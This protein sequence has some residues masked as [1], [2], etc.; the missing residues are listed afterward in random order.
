MNIHPKRAVSAILSAV[1]LLGIASPPVQALGSSANIAEETDPRLCSHHEA[2]T[3]ACG[4]LTGDCTFVCPEH[5]PQVLPELHEDMTDGTPAEQPEA[6]EETT[7]PDGS[8]QTENSEQ[9]DLIPLVPAEPAAPSETIPAMPLTPVQP[10]EDA[11]SDALEM[12]PGAM[13]PMMVMARAKME[14]YT[15]ATSGNHSH[16]GDGSY[17]NPYNLFDDAVKNVMPGGTIIIKNKAFL[18]TLNETGSLPYVI[19]KN[20]TIKSDDPNNPAM[21]QV[22]SGGIVLGGNVTFENVNLN[23]ENRVHDAI[24]ANG[25][26]LTLKNV[27][28][29]NGSREI[30]LFAGHLYAKGSST[31]YAHNQVGKEGKIIITI[32][33]PHLAPLS[34]IHLGNIYAGSMNGVFNGNATIE[35]SDSNEGKTKFIGEVY[36]CGA[37]EADPGNMLDIKEPNPPVANT[38]YTTS[39]TVIMD[40]N[41]LPLRFSEKN[42]GIVIDGNAG[43]GKKADVSIT[44]SSPIQNL[45][46]QNIAGLTVNGSA[47]QPTKDSATDFD[48]IA[49]N[50]GA[51][52]DLSQIPTATTGTLSGNGT[53]TLKREG[54]LTVRNSFTGQLTF[55]TQGAWN[56]KSGLVDPDHTYVTIPTDSTGNFKFTPHQGQEG[57]TFAAENKTDWKAIKSNGA[58][59]IP[60]LTQLDIDSVHTH[61]TIYQENDGIFHISVEYPLQ[62]SF[63][64]QDSSKDT[65]PPPPPEL[66]DIFDLFSCSVNSKKL[67]FDEENGVYS[68]ADIPIWLYFSSSTGYP[69]L[70]IQRIDNT[71]DNYDDTDYRAIP[72]GKYEIEI[73]YPTID[74]TMLSTKAYLESIPNPP[75]PPVKDP[76][77]ANSQIKV[78]PSKESTTFGDSI[79]VTANISKAP[80]TLFSARNIEENNAY[81]YVNGTNTKQS[82]PVINGNSIT[83]NN[84][85]ITTGNGFRAGENQVTVVYGGGDKITSLGKLNGSTGTANITVQKVTPNVK[86][87]DSSI[88]EIYNGTG[89]TYTP[90]NLTVEVLGE[91]ISN[92]ITSVSYTSKD[93]SPLNQPPILPGEYKTKITVA[94]GDTYQEETIDGPQITIQKATPKVSISHSFT[95]DGKVFLEATVQE[96]VPGIIPTGKVTFSVGGTQKTPVNLTYGI[97]QLTIDKPNAGEHDIQATYT[98][99]TGSA[100]SS[101]KIYNGASS[102]ISKLNIADNHKP[103]TGITLNQKTLF[104]KQTDNP[105]KLT[106]TF[107]PQDATNK[108]VTWASSDDTIATVTDGTITPKSAGTATIQARS[109]EGGHIASCFVTVSETDIKVQ[110]VEIS[111]P[112]TTLKVGEKSQLSAIIRP[113]NATTR[114]VKWES[115]STAVSIDSSTGMIT[116]NSV[117]SAEIT[118]IVGDQTAT[119]TI[120]VSN[121]IP[122]TN[123]QLDSNNLSLAQG[124]TIQ[125]IANITP[126]NATNANVIWH[127]DSEDVKVDQN[128]WVKAVREG[129]SATI[130]ASVEKISS[131]NAKCKINVTAPTSTIVSV[132]KIQLNRTNLT[133]DAGEEVTLYA[134]VSPHDATNKKFTWHSS[135]TD[136][137]VDQ[138][139]LVKAIKAGGHATITVT[140]D[141]GNK[142]ATCAVTVKGTTPPPTPAPTIK[143]TP[144]P[145]SLKVNGT[146]EL[147][148]TVTNENA[149]TIAWTVETN[150]GVISLNPPI[151]QKTV[152]VTA[153]HAGDAT[154]K[155]T[156]TSQS[157]QT[158]EKTATVKVTDTPPTPTPPTIS[159][160]PKKMDLE[161]GNTETLK[162]TVTNGTSGKVEWSVTTGNNLITLIPSPDGKTDQVT[163]KGNQTGTATV[164]AIY[165]DKSGQKAED[166]A[167]VEVTQKP[168]PSNPTISIEPKTIKLEV[169]NTETLKATVTNGT[170]GTVTWSVTQ[171]SEFITLQSLAENTTAQVTA[172]QAGTATVTATYTD[173]KS[174]TTVTDTA[175]VEV[176]E[177][178]NPDKPAVQSVTI[179]SVDFSLEQGKSKILTVT[180]LP[181]GA[182][183]SVTWESDAT[184]I[185][186]VEPTSGL[187]TAVSAGTAH[188]TATSAAD[189]SKHHTITVTVTKPSIPV[190][191]VKINENSLSLKPGEKGKFTATVSPKDADQNVTWT[192]NEPTIVSVNSNTGEITAH[193]PGKATITATSVT[194]P[195]KKDSRIVTVIEVPITELKINES[196]LSLREGQ[197]AQ[198]TVKIAPDNATNPAV[199]W[200]SDNDSVLSV[201]QNGYITAHNKGVATITVASVAQ[202][203]KKD[204]RMISVT[205]SSS[206]GGGGSGGGGSSGGGSHKPSKPDNKP[207][208]PEPKPET[209]P[210]TPPAIP[211]SVK[212]Q[213]PTPGVPVITT[214]PPVNPTI[215][216]NFADIPQTHWASEPIQD[217]VSRGLF[218]GTEPNEFSPNESMSRGMLVTVLHR[219]AGEPAVQAVNQFTDVGRTYYT[220]AVTWA[221]QNHIVSGTSANTFSPNLMVTREELVV[222]LYRL[223]NP[224]PDTNGKLT[225]F[226]DTAKVSNWASAPMQ[227]AVKNEI[228]KGSDGALLPQQKLTRAEAAS[229][230]HRF[231]EKILHS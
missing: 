109:A 80:V 3:E 177:K 38:S 164:K 12:L 23:F 71:P 95:S 1:M 21:L 18:N 182:N 122:V 108:N 36:A 155:V 184:G 147:T 130:T 157:G 126:D 191:D 215:N 136:V 204:S 2:H 17:H 158:V 125:L 29:S 11:Q 212:P 32:N 75:K 230:I 100:D 168:T 226:S 185:A 98:P 224:V 10:I 216:T 166:T 173:T 16:A 202:P 156:Y 196:I 159:I 66:D 8:E 222:M 92:P 52:L 72:L 219:L 140:T 63:A 154:V 170:S 49:I 200:T 53:L 37:D 84:V 199:K 33:A 94:E 121:N 228:L 162:A 194:T 13:Q 115:K 64:S 206:G 229:L 220:D 114:D 172:K 179:D 89:I 183:K 44:V 39:G 161:V 55:Q 195:D 144:D 59:E 40:F 193:K 42:N 106:V 54:Q 101:D 189:K 137:T 209:K 35:V 74:G 135:S 93:G 165:T 22:R 207:A 90:K 47:I 131:L 128:G 28:R 62:I 141:D 83:F 139:G 123:I 24:F 178:T 132:E 138:N 5:T 14:V 176:T 7:Q 70:T 76:D 48:S 227:W 150:N 4:G 104:L 190:T 171:T 102:A 152:H 85:P 223:A 167:T 186:T 57:W 26:T 82:V 30:D 148:A 79:T 56:G 181:E 180:V 149:G 133:M 192:S 107:Q 27:L 205:A 110:S 58:K 187:V 116:A 129:G 119:C 88:T 41:S 213:Q 134:T 174:R 153:K 231:S 46:L 68:H 15:S 60:L 77:V 78:T 50:T 210:V 146:G 217:V 81:L 214:A 160:D 127:S 197:S 86:M 113:T 67:T 91:T 211:P 221:S 151:N 112:N 143:I 169:G 99:S 201:T 175:T 87:Q 111:A 61:K 25:H 208:K 142:T 43:N 105:S 163:V 19:D 96:L 65:S 20:I 203:E 198:L 45:K 51:E 103:L 97:A 34:S 225:G 9:I 117:G 120:T 188:I 145:L 218:V 31:P 73:Q 124:Q 118:A 6:P 69:A